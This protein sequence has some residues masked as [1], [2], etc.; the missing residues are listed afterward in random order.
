MNTE[1]I[2]F[3]AQAILAQN[4][5]LPNGERLKFDMKNW[6][7]TACCIAGWTNALIT[8][9]ENERAQRRARFL[10][11]REKTGINKKSSSGTLQSRPDYPVQRGHSGTSCGRPVAPC[12]RRF[13][14]LGGIEEPTWPAWSQSRGIPRVSPWKT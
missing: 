2:H 1:A 10:F 12:G 3:V 6:C 4:T 7:G 8:D 11:C 5:V 14:G 13:S 9:D